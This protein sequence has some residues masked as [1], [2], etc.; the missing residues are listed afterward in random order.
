MTTIGGGRHSMG[1][2][3]GWDFT[4]NWRGES[5]DEPP[6]AP[7]IPP[8]KPNH[9]HLLAMLEGERDVGTLIGKHSVKRFFRVAKA[10]GLKNS[11]DQCEI[12]QI[13]RCFYQ[14]IMMLH[15]E[16]S[17][18]HAKFLDSWRDGEGCTPLHN[19]ARQQDYSLV[20][21]FLKLG[22]NP[23]L[24]VEP[25]VHHCLSTRSIGEFASP[26]ACTRMVG[27]TALT[28]LVSEPG[29][30]PKKCPRIV[31][32]IIELLAT[33]F[34]PPELPPTRQKDGRG[35]TPLFAALSSRN[36]GFI[37]LLLRIDPGSSGIPN[38]AGELPLEVAFRSGLAEP[39]SLIM[40]FKSTAGPAPWSDARK[41]DLRLVARHWSSLNVKD[42]RAKTY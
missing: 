32:D 42:T 12:R 40:R 18:G 41:D 21:E 11:W 2:S 8:P 20:N 26:R 17:L 34:V 33:S 38:E 39:A 30:A 13:F 37:S 16:G 31:G 29:L 36:H 19:S 10:A 3:G 5:T 25:R 28:L 24:M 22:A 35:E 23:T 1:R 14:P 6:P 7:E 9:W 27:R 4:P 15:P